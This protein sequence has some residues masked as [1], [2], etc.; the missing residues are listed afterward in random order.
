MAEE[1]AKVTS[2]DALEAFRSATIVFLTKGKRAVDQATDEVRRTRQWVEG[3]RKLFWETEFR[4]RSRA[5]ERA[6]QE[7]VSA[8][9]SEF[10]ETMQLQK[11]A[12]RKAKAALDEASDKLRNIKKWTHNFDGVFDPLVKRL[13]TLRQYLEHDMPK[14][15]AYLGQAQITLESYTE[16]G[17]GGPADAPPTEATQ[18]QDQ[19][20]P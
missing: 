17:S 7:L 10:N 16:I 14:A 15:V 4:K 9:F 8:R 6:E 2:L 11:A 18:P 1:Q 13:D 12:V 20:H 5:L 19:I 3:D